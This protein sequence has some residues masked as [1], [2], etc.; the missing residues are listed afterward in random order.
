V[1]PTRARIARVVPQSRRVGGVE[2]RE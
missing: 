1:A 2:L